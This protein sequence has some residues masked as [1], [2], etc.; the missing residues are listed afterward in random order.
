MLLTSDTA[1][2]LARSSHFSVWKGNRVAAVDED[3]E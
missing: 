1:G 2:Q 3:E